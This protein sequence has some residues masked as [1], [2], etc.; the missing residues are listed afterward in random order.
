M[1]L[2]NLNIKNGLCISIGANIDSHFGKPIESILKARPLVENIIEKFLDRFSKRTTN[3]NS[4]NLNFEWSS[5]YD[6]SPQG[7]LG[8]QPNFINTI[9]L[10]R[11]NLLS[12]PTYEKAI[13]L[14]KKF[15]KLEYDFGR[16]KKFNSDRWPARSLDI[17]IVWWGNLS[18]D[19]NDLTL[20]HPRF[21]NRN[22][23]ITPLSE[24][25]KRTQEIKILEEERW[26][27]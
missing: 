3:E 14:L 19:E 1:E 23:V 15:E 12:S 24:I 8:S 6:T 9:L 27:I 17:D 5:L 2:S 18:V 21:V 4:L 26:V 13:Y 20:P 11:S 16:R 10:T 22:F 25:L 7:I